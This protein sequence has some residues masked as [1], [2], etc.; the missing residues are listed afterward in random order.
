M[1]LQWV[2]SPN[3]E[4]GREGHA[5]TDIVLHWMDGTLAAAGAVFA[6][7]ATQVS[8]T[9]GIED[10]TEHQWVNIA[11]TSWNAGTHAENLISVSIEHS[12]DP[13]RPASASTITTSVNR[14]VTLIRTVPTLSVDRIYPHNRFVATDCPGTLPIAAMINR[15]R[16][17]LNNPFPPTRK[18]NPMLL[19]RGINDPKVYVTDGISKRWIRPGELSDLLQLCGQTTPH[20]LGQYTVDRMPVVIGLP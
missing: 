4:K 9:Y 14:M 10:T 13:K 16:A 7:P 6:N 19:I 17:I 18:A 15:V 11:D 12:A 8:A 5:P 2:G 1:T 20:I 3:Y